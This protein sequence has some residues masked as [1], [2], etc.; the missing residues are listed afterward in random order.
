[1]GLCQMLTKGH[2]MSRGRPKNSSSCVSVEYPSQ[3]NSTNPHF[4]GFHPPSVY[5]YAGSGVL[6]IFIV[7]L[8]PSGIIIIKISTG[9]LY[10][11]PSENWKNSCV[12]DVRKFA[13]A[14]SGGGSPL[15]QNPKRSRFANL[16]FHSLPSRPL[17]EMKIIHIWYFFFFCLLELFCTR[18]G[19]L[20][21]NHFHLLFIIFWMMLLIIKYY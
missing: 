5:I 17:V 16:I 1:M 10:N 12:V 15:S 11:T 21:A 14:E 7:M 4:F 3:A 2:C 8:L 13:L 18:E 20:F 9:I 19:V 6:F